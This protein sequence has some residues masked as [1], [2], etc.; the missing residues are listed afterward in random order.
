MNKTH[1]NSSDI[2][3]HYDTKIKV[4]I[5]TAYQ[6]KPIKALWVSNVVNID[7]PVIQDDGETYKKHILTMFDTCEAFHINT[8]YFQ[9]RTTNDAFYRSAINPYS[10]FLTGKEGTE[11]PFDVFGWIIEET[12]QRDI[13]IHAWCNPYRIS[14][15]GNL[16]IEDYLE[17]CDDKNFAKQH[18][19]SIILDD[20]GKLILN[21]A[22]PI[23]KDH[24]FDSMR[25]LCETYDIDGIHF[26]DYFYPYGEL[27]DTHNDLK[28]YDLY[29]EE[30][31]TLEDFRRRQVNDVIRGVKDV[32]KAV[33]PSIVYSVSPFGIWKNKASDPTGSNTAPSCSESYYNQFADSVTWIQEEWIDAIIPQIY[34]QFGHQIAPFADL[35]DFWVQAVQGTNVDLL[36]G[37]AAYR[38]G[39]KEDWLDEMELIHQLHYANQYKEVTGNV[40]F[41]Y[42]NFIDN[43]EATAGI[44]QLKQLLDKV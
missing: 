27:S 34:F 17:T 16:S 1:Y 41:T 31:E 19:E 10:R 4:D 11:P 32:I 28:E 39:S 44:K 30:N 40:F 13:Q 25:E 26:D 43:K 29:K 33:N 5:P 14:A 2:I 6:D 18:P 3:C 22:S 8:L 35:V 21:P 38:M 36:I 20:K 9:V 15:N 37:H 42:H 23:V 12:H 7:L 24:I